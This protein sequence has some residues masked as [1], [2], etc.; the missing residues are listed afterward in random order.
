MEVKQHWDAEVSGLSL[1]SAAGSRSGLRLVTMP[2]SSYANMCDT[3]S[4]RYQGRNGDNVG[5]QIG[6]CRRMWLIYLTFGQPMG[7]RRFSFFLFSNSGPHLLSSC[8]PSGSSNPARRTFKVSGLLIDVPPPRHATSKGNPS[9]AS[10][11]TGL[12]PRH[13]IGAAT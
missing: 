6:E 1:H 4:V 3:A 2:E 11:C 12:A 13:I 5:S 8:S 9:T 7:R 10:A